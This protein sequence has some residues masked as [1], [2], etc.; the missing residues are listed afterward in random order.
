V[1][2]GDQR[3]SALGYIY[4]P[5]TIFRPPPAPSPAK[6]FPS[7]VNVSTDMLPH[8]RKVLTRRSSQVET[9]KQFLVGI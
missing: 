3:P 9:G 6:T 4:Q 2:S 8:D 7:L 5:E 1:Q